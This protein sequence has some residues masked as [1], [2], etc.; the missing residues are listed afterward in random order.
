MLRSM[1]GFGAA[2]AA[3]ENFRL[4][5]EIRAVNQR[6]LDLSFRMPRGLYQYE[7][8]M[9]R[10]IKEKLTRGKIEVFVN[11][12]DF[13]ENISALSV[14]IPLAKAYQAALNEIADKLNLPRN[15]SAVQ[16]AAYPGVLASDENTLQGVEPVLYQSLSK[17]LESLDTM[18]VREGER[19]EKDFLSRLKELGKL[20]NDAEKLGNV[21]VAAHRERIRTTV[22]EMLDNIVDEGRLLQEVALYA[23]RVNYTEE[24]VRLR[25]HLHQFERMLEDD[26]S[27]GRKLD[28]L[29]QEMNREANTIGSKGNHKDVARIVVD[30][31]SEIEKLREQ[32][33]NIE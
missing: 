18:R 16:I 28:F 23:D 6:F 21:V 11:L 13:R 5:L 7:E 1:T 30:M 15:D 14:D 10:R 26:G 27:H 12:Q 31:K 8:E 19:I 20:V 25:S 3:D 29:I 32:V 17:A 22:Q 33:Q 2:D 9:T 4:H 24:V